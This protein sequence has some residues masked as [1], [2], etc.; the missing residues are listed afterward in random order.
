[1]TCVCSYVWRKKN[2]ISGFTLRYGS[3][4]NAKYSHSSPRNAQIVF[5]NANESR[6][7]AAIIILLCAKNGRSKKKRKKTFNFERTWFIDSTDS[8]VCYTSFRR[9][10]TSRYDW[11]R[12]LQHCRFVFLLKY[13]TFHVNRVSEYKFDS[14]STTRACVN[15][16]FQLTMFSSNTIATLRQWICVQPNPVFLRFVLCLAKIRFFFFLL[17]KC[18]PNLNEWGGDEQRLNIRTGDFNANIMLF[19]FII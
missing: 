6:I 19:Y 1:M 13:Y 14:C 15:T 3:D 5:E 2:I 9:D 12:V 4:V 10:E 17:L 8:S 7:T 11:K 18:R 16:Y